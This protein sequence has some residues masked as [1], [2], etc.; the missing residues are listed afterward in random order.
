MDAN[1]YRDAG[2]FQREMN[3][4]F[5][6]HWLIAGRS[7]S[8][9]NPGDWLTYEGHGQSV[10]VTRQFDG[11]LSAFHNVCAHRGTAIVTKMSGN[12]AKCFVCPYHGWTY[13]ITGKLIAVPERRDFNSDHLKTR[14]LH[15]SVDQWGG[16]IWIN[17]SRD[18]P[19]KSLD[20]FIGQEILSDLNEF[21]MEDMFV[22]ELIEYDVPINY[23][24]IVDGFNEVYHVT[25]LHKTPPEFTQAVRHSTFRVLGDNSMSIMPRPEFIEHISNTDY[26]HHNY[27]ICHY[28][29]FPNTIF[30][31]FYNHLQLFQPIP[32]SVDRTKFLCW[33]L[34]YK[35][36]EQDLRYARYKNKSIRDWDQFKIV[37]NQ[38]ISIYNELNRTKN[39]IAFNN[40]I[41]S[42]RE[43]KIL[44]YHKSMNS[45]SAEIKV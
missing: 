14:A 10:I 4:V 31:C 23:K 37:I 19:P 38:D 15:V 18:R 22:Y 39:S 21:K 33:E 1:V 17:M 24:A 36:D 20:D 28:L 43:N 11:S 8:I 29:I 2:Q 35:G 32:V 25:Q 5:A 45:K 12:S 42:E 44:R 27:A 7:D 40:Q 41:L 13:D 9:P 26:D 6:T 30:N 34:L 3:Q 16:W